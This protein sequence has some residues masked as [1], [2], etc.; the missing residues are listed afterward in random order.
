MAR[1]LPI[2]TIGHSTLGIGKFVERLQAAQVTRVID[3]RTITRSRTNPQFNEATLPGALAPFGIGYEHLA[4]LGG[5]RGRSKDVSPRVNGF[6]DNPSFHNYADYSLHPAFLDGL[7]EL[8]EKGQRERVA[9]MCAE[10][11]WWRC[12]RRIVADWLIAADETV[13]HIMVSRIE[14]ARLNPGAHVGPQG[15]VTY[16]AQSAA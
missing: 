8:R 1:R 2:H 16:P 6:W 13:R 12:H 14:E 4:A 5:R 10:A 11:V 3:V 7:T 15:S 9:I